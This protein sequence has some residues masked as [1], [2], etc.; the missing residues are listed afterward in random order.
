M[1]FDRGTGCPPSVN[2]RATRGWRGHAALKRSRM[3]QT[4][5]SDEL[6]DCARA[7]T[8]VLALFTDGVIEE[9]AVDCQGIAH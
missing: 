4:S 1:A 3:S 8:Q 2:R 5:T 9:W 6:D 7:S